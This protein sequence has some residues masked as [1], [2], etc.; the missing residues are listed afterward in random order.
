MRM[1]VLCCCLNCLHKHALK[2]IV[3][4]ESA[5]QYIHCCLPGDKEVC[6]VLSDIVACR[7]HTLL[8][9]SP[10]SFTCVRKLRLCV[11]QKT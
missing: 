10:F 4:K 9:V 6:V 2:T 3:Q 8:K 11:C 5:A 1:L 7:F